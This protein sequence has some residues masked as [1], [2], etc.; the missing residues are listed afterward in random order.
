MRRYK[1]AQNLTEHERVTYDPDFIGYHC[2]RSPRSEYDD[3]ILQEYAE[4]YFPQIL[5]A[6][7][8]NLRDQAAQQGL[9]D[10]PEDQFSDEH[11][12][13]AENAHEFLREH[14]ISWIFVSQNRLLEPYGGY[15]Y[16]TF[17]PDSDILAVFD[18]PGVEDMA[19]A[20]LYDA[21]KVSP[22]FLQVPDTDA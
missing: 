18:D 6:L 11:D 7:P 12:E 13:W 10:T 14:N 19:D 15:C 20:Y 16:Y 22:R 2:Q 17:L 21:N 9:L 1:H 5:D 8:H 3:V 4:T